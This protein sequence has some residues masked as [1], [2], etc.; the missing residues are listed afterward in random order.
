MEILA[1][2]THILGMFWR[3]LRLYQG[4]LLLLKA[5]L[6]EEAAFLARS[7]FE[8]SLRLKQMAD[9]PQQRDRLILHWVNNLIDGKG[10]TTQSRQGSWTR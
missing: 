2:Q 3:S 1:A 9:E 10:G 5:E 8:A 6:P 7:L 4:A